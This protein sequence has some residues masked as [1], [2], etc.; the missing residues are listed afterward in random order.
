MSRMAGPGAV[1]SLPSNTPS[2]DLA[3]VVGQPRLPLPDCVRDG[4]SMVWEPLEGPC[5]WDVALIPGLQ[6][7]LSPWAFRA[8]CC[9]QGDESHGGSVPRLAAKGYFGSFPWR[10]Q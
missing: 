10:V 2:L 9:I 7:E 5:T 4:T 8:Q 3:R 6:I 1:Q